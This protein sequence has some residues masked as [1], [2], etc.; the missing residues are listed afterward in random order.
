MATELRI[1]KHMPDNKLGG[2]DLEILVVTFLLC[3]DGHNPFKKT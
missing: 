1:M 2:L 3:H